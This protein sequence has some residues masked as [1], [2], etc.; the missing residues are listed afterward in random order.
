[1]IGP[2][3]RSSADPPFAVLVGLGPAF[4]PSSRSHPCLDFRSQSKRC[5]FGALNRAT[6]V[7][8]SRPFDL[9]RLELKDPRRSDSGIAIPIGSFEI[10]EQYDIHGLTKA[11]EPR[12][13]MSRSDFDS[14]GEFIFSATVRQMNM[15]DVFA[16]MMMQS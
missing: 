15:S 10:Q 1:M 5:D 12:I 4:A 2:A 14:R 6:P 9:T 7:V 11:I 3:R 13:R 16:W 8:L